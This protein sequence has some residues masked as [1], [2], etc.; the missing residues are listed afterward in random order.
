MLADSCLVGAC[1]VV[2]RQMSSQCVLMRW[3]R[4]GAVWAP[5]CG[6]GVLVVRLHPHDLITSHSP[7]LLGAALCRRY[8]SMGIRENADVQCAAYVLQVGPLLSVCIQS[9]CVSAADFLDWK[10]SVLC[11]WHFSLTQHQENSVS[12]N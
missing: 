9:V 10:L 12:V 6:A 5:I 7:H 4:Q 2:C 11:S 8:L 1:S 3:E